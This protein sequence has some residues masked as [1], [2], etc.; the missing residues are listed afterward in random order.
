MR[1]TIV[2]QFYRPDIAPTAYLAATLAEHRAGRGDEVTVIAGKGAYAA[3]GVHGAGGG[4]DN[5]RVL[6]VWT[7]GLGK[8]TNLK[9]VVD[10]GAYYFF[11]MWKLLTLRR[12]DVIVSLTT[13]PLIAWAA[14]LHKRLH[15]RTRV[16][17]WNMDSYPDA[18]ERTGVIRAGGFIASRIR[19]RNRAIFRGIDHM[20]ALD[21]AMAELLCSQYASVNPGLPVTIIPNFEEASYFPREAAYPPAALDGVNLDG[22]FV[23]LYMGNMGYGHQFDTV[24]DAAE[25]LRDTPALFLFVGGGRNWKSVADEAARRGLSN[26]VMH[27]YIPK[28]RTGAVMAAAHCAL[29]TL[30]DDA[31]G[32]MSPSKIH[33]NLALGLPLIYVGPPKSNVDE[34]ITHYDCGVS[35]RHGESDA[36][37]SFVRGMME[38]P[39]RHA[40]LRAQARRAFESSYCDTAAMPRFDRV[41][42]AAVSGA[43]PEA[44]GE[45]ESAPATS[46]AGASS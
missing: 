16:I 9:R 37:V 4:A 42:E 14:T 39:G 31:L 5:P 11:A 22:R 34:A 43:V 12:Q 45:G 8:S 32:V 7:P 40:E 23:V 6:R 3:K 46:Y 35:L 19:G 36:L 25:R 41:I 2:N 18:A 29:V 13:P 15:R 1:I 17:L 28:E 33:A 21:R 10:Y 27:G 20:V 26:V 38:S 24:L 30:R 44:G